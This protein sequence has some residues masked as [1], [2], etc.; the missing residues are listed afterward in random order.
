MLYE[1]QLKARNPG[2][3]VAATSPV[4]IELPHFK[5]SQRTHKNMPL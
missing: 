4:F 5:P 2:N 3:A 1:Y